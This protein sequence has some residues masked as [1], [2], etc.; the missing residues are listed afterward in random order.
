MAVFEDSGIF[1]VASVIC[2]GGMRG[3][4]SSENIANIK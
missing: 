3:T 4:C 1:M 2:M